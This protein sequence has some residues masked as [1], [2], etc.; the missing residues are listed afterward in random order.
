MK[1]L[2]SVPDSLAL[3][4]IA[5]PPVLPDATPWMGLRAGK[6]KREGGEG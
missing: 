4:A 6:G 1:P 2:M 5:S 3:G